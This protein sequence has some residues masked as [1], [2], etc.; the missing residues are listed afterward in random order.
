LDRLRTRSLRR[1]T[2]L[3]RRLLPGEHLRKLSRW[4][5]HAQ[6]K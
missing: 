2:G 4:V 1:A 3:L 6:I 5:W